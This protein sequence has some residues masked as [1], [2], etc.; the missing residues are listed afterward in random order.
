VRAA[1]RGLSENTL[2]IEPSLISKQSR[3]EGGSRRRDAPDRGAS[4]HRDTRVTLAGV[5]AASFA[6]MM[7]D[8][9][10]LLGMANAMLE[11]GSDRFL[12]KGTNGRWQDELTP[13]DHA[14]ADKLIARFSPGLRRWI[15]GGR[16]AAGDPRAS[17]E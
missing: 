17:S 9:P 5:E 7:R 14:L 15:V 8:G 4:R 12:F 13:A 16:I 11:G 10:V 2:G 6:A 3:P 1:Q